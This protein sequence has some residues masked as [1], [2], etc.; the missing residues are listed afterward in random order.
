MKRFVV[1]S[2]ASLFCVVSIISAEPLAQML[3]AT[4]SDSVIVLNGQELDLEQQPVIINGRT[5]LP[6]REIS[7]INGFEVEWD[8]ETKDIFLEQDMIKDSTTGLI[9]GRIRYDYYGTDDEVA[10]IDQYSEG[11]RRILLKAGDGKLV[12][13]PHEAAQIA[14]KHILED[15]LMPSGEAY[16]ELKFDPNKDVWVVNTVYYD[17]SILGFVFYTINRVEGTIWKYFL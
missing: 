1:A 10:D 17:Y 14:S 9:E 6:L 13:S 15:D 2:L 8:E 5:Y 7:E 16:L 4:Q 3:T 11:F 12:R